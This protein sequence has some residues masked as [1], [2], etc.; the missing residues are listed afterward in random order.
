MAKSDDRLLFLNMMRRENKPLT[1]ITN[2]E[3]IFSRARHHFGVKTVKGN[4]RTAHDS[5]PTP[6]PSPPVRS[7]EGVDAPSP[8]TPLPVLSGGSAFG[9]IGGEWQRLAVTSRKFGGG[10]LK[11]CA[12]LPE[13]SQKTG[14]F[15]PE[16]GLSQNLLPDPGGNFL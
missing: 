14:F 2:K 8:R 3:N 6:S 16:P 10:L 4:F 1:T 5:F 13:P 12:I 9:G 11:N 15:L 7:G